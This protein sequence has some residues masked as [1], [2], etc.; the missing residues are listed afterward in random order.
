MVQNLVL[1]FHA[2][3]AFMV[4]KH[5]IKVTLTKKVSLYLNFRTV[6]LSSNLGGHDESPHHGGDYVKEQSG[7]LMVVKNK[8]QRKIRISLYNS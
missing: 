1:I 2:C 6:S 4:T 3:H 5:F 8:K 7:L